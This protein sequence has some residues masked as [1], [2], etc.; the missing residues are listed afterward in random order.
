MYNQYE[1]VIIAKYKIEEGK[2]CP[3]IMAK[4]ENVEF[5]VSLFQP[6]TN[7]P[8]SVY[9]AM[10]TW[11][12]GSEERTIEVCARTAYRDVQRNLSGI[13]KMPEQNKRTW[14]EDIEA[15]IVRCIGDLLAQDLSDKEAFDAWHKSACEKLCKESDKHNISKWVEWMENGYTY[16]LSQK[17]VNMTIKNMLVMEQ[18]D[19]YFEPIKQHLHIPVDS[20]VM[21]AASG[22]LEIPIPCKNGGVGKYSL[23]GSKSDSKPWSR[24]EYGDYITFQEE[25][26]KATPCPMDWEFGAWNRIKEKRVTE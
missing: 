11:L 10:L 12:F 21:D 23:T 22:D 20:Y 8:T 2:G 19:S 6:L 5:L 26:R 13:S 1:Y 17:I 18:W 16:G 25:V 3:N 7:F 4:K 14:R 15:L 9:D 24:W